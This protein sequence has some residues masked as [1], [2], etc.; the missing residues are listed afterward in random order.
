MVTVVFDYRYIVSHFLSFS[1][2]RLV[3]IED[4]I[5]FREPAEVATFTSE[6]IAAVRQLIDGL[7]EED[8]ELLLDALDEHED[9][10]PLIK[11]LAW[12]RSLHI[13]SEM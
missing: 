7:D 9:D 2:I 12:F 13:R 11:S 1:F 10:S 8:Q 3:V 5:D 6:A 4:H